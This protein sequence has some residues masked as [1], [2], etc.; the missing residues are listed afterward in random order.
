MLAR[1]IAATFVDVGCYDHEYGVDA[2]QALS[3]EF[4]VRDGSRVSRDI[5]GGGD[6]RVEGVEFGGGA[7]V[8]V[9]VVLGLG[10]EEFQ[11]LGASGAG[12]A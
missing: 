8:D 10:E 4:L 9:E 1:V 6:G 3:D 7:G 2:A 5:F 11:E 12:G